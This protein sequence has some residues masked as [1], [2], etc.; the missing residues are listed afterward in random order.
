[1]EVLLRENYQWIEAKFNIKTGSIVKVDGT[2]I[3][4]TD[5]VSI[6]DDER[7]EYVIC[8]N[9]GEI[10]RNTPEC[11]EKHYNKSTNS[12]ACMTC[13]HLRVWCDEQLS[14][15][16]ELKDDG[17][18]EQTTKVKCHLSCASRGFSNPP[19]INSENARSVCRYAKCRAQG[20]KSITDVFTE[21]SEVFDSIATVDALDEGMWTLEQRNSDGTFLY[22][23]KKRFRLYAIVNSMGIV[24]HFRYDYNRIRYD[25]A[26]SAKYNKVFWMDCGLYAASNSSVSDS[27]ISELVSVVAKIYKE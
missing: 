18:Y 22:R 20:M 13:R 9:C 14:V 26:Y 19:D 2:K 7:A 24:D 11:L 5:I 1:M 16:Y 10:I 15:D 21:Y 6:K 23:A 12:D 4:P 17:S 25:F 8:K 3:N 27:R